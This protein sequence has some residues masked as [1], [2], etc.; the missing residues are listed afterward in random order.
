M[1]FLIKVRNDISLPRLTF[2]FLSLPCTLTLQFH[3]L[4][5][6]LH[7]GPSS[8]P[9]YQETRTEMLSKYL[10][11]NIPP[12]DAVPKGAASDLPSQ[13]C[14]TFTFLSLPCTF[15]LKKVTTDWHQ[16]N[17]LNNLADPNI[18][19]LFLKPSHAFADPLLI[20]IPRFLLH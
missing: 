9:S 3:C 2:I 19:L 18:L 11:N 15:K 16:V 8:K 4:A 6:S 5:L 1:S 14:L 12:K 10:K 20:K 7:L 17:L 13:I